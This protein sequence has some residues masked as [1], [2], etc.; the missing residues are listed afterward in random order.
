MNPID[1]WMLLQALIKHLKCEEIIMPKFFNQKSPKPCELGGPRNFYKFTYKNTKLILIGEAHYDMPKIMVDKY[2]DVF[3]QFVA[4]NNQ[5]KVFIE[6]NEKDYKE[7]KTSEKMPFM[8]S[9][10]N[11]KHASHLEIIPSDERRL[12]DDFINLT[13]YLYT[14]KEMI[15][16]ILEKYNKKYSTNLSELPFPADRDP[17]FEMA[18]TM[19]SKLRDTKI[20]FLNLLDL[21]D[22]S[23]GKVEQLY[24]K[25]SKLDESIRAHIA[26]FI[27]K[28][29]HG[30][31]LTL[32]LYDEY[33]S[34]EHNKEKND[35]EIAKTP[36]TEA[37]I[38]L[39]IH[40][41]TFDRF[42]KL[43][44]VIYSYIIDF[45]DATL[46]C[47]LWEELNNDDEKILIVVNGDEHTEDLASI[48]KK[49]CKSEVSVSQDPK[50]VII[51]PERINNYLR[52][53]VDLTPKRSGMCAIL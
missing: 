18:M 14:M 8:R 48:F 52:N 44:D 51:S 45:L 32:E 53:N 2:A 4:E 22:S 30:L 36:L 24:D 6:M 27:V 47:K 9:M 42:L 19:L 7:E 34:L 1:R 43:Q 16:S 20:T 13:L 38:E 26:A 28:I 37:C 50:N 10:K 21:L 25:H 29:N 23:L 33:H 15:T 11:L 35:N 46:F 5:I 41:R 40:K 49:L 12:D 31:T 17:F 39:M 3:N